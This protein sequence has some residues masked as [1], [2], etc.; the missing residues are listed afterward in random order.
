MNIFSQKV[1][2]LFPVG[3]DVGVW[4]CGCVGVWVCGCVGVWVCGCVDW[5]VSILNE[6]RCKIDVRQYSNRAVK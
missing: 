3:G 5:S 2:M 6:N 4:V 1:L